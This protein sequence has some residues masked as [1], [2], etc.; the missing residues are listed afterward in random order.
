MNIKGIKLKSWSDKLRAL[1]V[2][3]CLSYVV[4][5]T[6]C[7]WDNQSNRDKRV[8][9]ALQ[10]L[11]EKE[12]TILLRVANSANTDSVAGLKI[13]PRFEV[14]GQEPSVKLGLYDLDGNQVGGY[15]DGQETVPREIRVPKTGF[16][17][18][19]LKGEELTVTDAAS[20]NLN[21]IVSGDGF[22]S[23]AASFTVLTAEDIEIS[24][25]DVLPKSASADM[26]SSF[27]EA[28]V[29]MTGSVVTST[30]T[31]VTAVRPD[32]TDAGKILDGASI[33]IDI[34][35]GTEFFNESGEPYKPVG[36][37][38]ASA[39]LMSADPKGLSDS[40]NNPLFAFPGGLDVSGLEGDTP[41]GLSRDDNFS[42]ISA[43]FVAIEIEDEAGNKVSRF[44]GEGITI[45]FEVPKSTVNPSTNAPIQL[46]DETIP[47]WSYNEKTAKW[48][49][50]GEADITAENA[51]TFT[52]EKKIT[53]LS[54]YNLDWYSS[55]SCQLTVN[56]FDQ[57][58]VANSQS[59][60]FSLARDSGGWARQGTPWG[61]D[62]FLTFYRLPAF[63]GNFDLLDS[64]GNSLLAS[65]EFE[66][67]V[68]S[69]VDGE[70]GVDVSDFC[71]GSAPDGSATITANL[72]VSNPPTIDISPTIILTC[73]SD[74]TL[75][76]EA[77]AGYY[78]L[79]EGN[80]NYQSNGYIETSILELNGLTEGAN[81]KLYWYA[82]N[83]WGYTEFTA[84]TDTNEI[85]VEVPSMCPTIEQIVELRKVCLDETTSEVI[86]EEPATGAVYGLYST[87][88]W[89]GFWGYANANGDADEDLIEGQPYYGYGYEYF[90]DS[91]Y[92]GRYGYY[93]FFYGSTT[94]SADSVTAEV[95]DL[96]VPASDPFCSDLVQLDLAK[97]TVVASTLTLLADGIET[98]ILTV[99]LKDSDDNDYG[100]SSG[101]LSFELPA[102]ISQVSIDDNEDGTYTAV[103]SATQV[104][105]V[106]FTPKIDGADMSNTVTVDFQAVPVVDAAQSQVVVSTAATS[107]GNDVIVTVTLKQADDSSYDVSGGELTLTGSPAGASFSNIIDN[108]TGSYSATMS[109][110]TPEEY[111]VTA[112][113][114]GIELQTTPTVTL[115]L[116]D[117]AAS[118]I[119][120]DPTDIIG[121][122]IET[123]TIS[124]NQQ[125]ASSVG[126]GGH[127]VALSGL[128]IQFNA[129][130]IEEQRDLGNGNYEVD[131]SCPNVFAGSATIEVQVDSIVM[132]T[133]EVN[134]N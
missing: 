118:T 29:G 11:T 84:T 57:N 124:L 67:V 87:D 108:G 109:S 48:A 51:N 76:E 134:C 18:L 59:L 56:V 86:K 80:Y 68:T 89:Q 9:T 1:V 111:T 93:H 131:L 70:T 71:F 91:S 125:D 42:F 28:A 19:I 64:A 39:V 60:S 40:S 133:F 41:D 35:A 54:Y 105:V 66:G 123:V 114:G 62:S 16:L 34:P 74:N 96:I 32:N 73:P 119:T 23:N 3:T 78:Y 33:N 129:L 36:V 61:E 82:S 132:G 4:G 6:G 103:F 24:V 117:A 8:N 107:V 99:T 83:N 69:V 122:A 120:P 63:E 128:A 26:A 45:A 50:E 22:F 65:I 30:V 126:H 21:L 95:I 77:G 90:Y 104:A 46:V 81:Y 55:D 47:L 44:G 7:S 72:N 97:S 100:R 102:G 85:L 110:A 5:L 94:F 27:I 116:V 75:T 25:V 113:V 38:S 14:E 58:G 17:S 130:V 37:V 31:L 2:I 13:I 15:D 112:T 98:V 106:V 88:Y 127:T 20:I 115:T 121:A 52:V 92:E 12:I 43:G 10:A 53:H 101:T 49:S 79:Y